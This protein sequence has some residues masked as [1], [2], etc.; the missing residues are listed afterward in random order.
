MYRLDWLRNHMQHSDTYARWLHQQFAYEFADQPLDAWQREFAEGQ[1]SGEWQCLVALD[2]E[3]LLGGAA[4]AE[5][6]L[7]GRDDLGP[8]LACV[9]T[10]PE[11]RGQGIAERLIEGICEQARS[12]GHGRLYLH[13]QDRADY[14]ARRG[15]VPLERFQAW[16]AEHT[17]MWRA[18]QPGALDGAA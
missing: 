2:G 10:T 4:L 17:L 14:Y 9:F 5:D 15:W 16:G 13:T 6:D 3:H 8:W 7:P 18:L 12:Q 11:A 1:R